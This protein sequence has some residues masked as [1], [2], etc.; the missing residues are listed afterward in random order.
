M[1]DDE[2]RAMLEET[3][4]AQRANAAYRKKRAPTPTPT[5][6]APVSA[7]D[8]AALEKHCAHIG[9]PLPPSFRQFLRISDG[10]PGY[11][12]Y[13]R[14]SLR[15]ARDIVESADSDEEE[16]D[17]YD[18]LHKFVIVSGDTTEFIAFDERSIDSAGEP[19]VVWVGLSG[20]ETAYANFEDLLWSQR[21]F[22]KDVLE[23]HIA[24]RGSL[25]DN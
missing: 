20:D 16:W 8:L 24:D 1:N 12:Q 6:R 23:G 21:E 17:D 13:V 22:Q 19:A 25:P 10:V 11:M 14:M 15:S 18:P 9:I 3:L 7:D 5:L 4:R 2:M